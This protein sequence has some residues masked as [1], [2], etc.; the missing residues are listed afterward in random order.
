MKKR[1]LAWLLTL[2]MVL[3][4][5][6][7]IGSARAE[8]GQ[9]PDGQVE[10]SQG[11]ETLNEGEEGG[12]DP[13]EEYPDGEDPFED[14]DPFGI[15]EDEIPDEEP[16]FEE[17]FPD[18]AFRKVVLFYLD[19]NSDG[20]LSDEEW[21][22]IL[23][24]TFLD[25]TP[26]YFPEEAKPIADDEVVRSLAGIEHFVGL[27]E[28]IDCSDRGVEEIDITNNSDL[29]TLICNNNSITELDLRWN[30]NLAYVEC[31]GNE[32]LT[33]YLGS[34]EY[35]LR[36]Y[37]QYCHDGQPFDDEGHHCFQTG[38]GGTITF[39]DDAVF[40]YD[41]ELFLEYLDELGGEEYFDDEDQ[42]YYLLGEEFDVNQDGEIDDEEALLVKEIDAPWCF[43][44]SLDGIERFTNLEVLTGEN[45]YVLA[46]AD[47]SANTKLRELKLLGTS[48]T[49]IDLSAN[50][51]LEKL[52]ITG[53][54]Q[55]AADI[56]LSHNTKLKEL[57][58]Y[59][60]SF[61]SFSIEGLTNLVKLSIQ[62]SEV[63]TIPGLS[64]AVLLEDLQLGT[65]Q[66]EDHFIMDSIDLGNLTK[67]KN[68]WL[69]NCGLKT[70]IGLDKINPETLNLRRN[71]LTSLDVSSMTNL[72]ELLCFSNELET[73]KLGGQTFTELEL[74]NNK[75]TADGIVGFENISVTNCLDVSDVAL[76]TLDVA[77]FNELTRLYCSDCG[78]QE[79]DVTNNPNLLV[80]DCHGNS[81]EELDVSKCPE[82]FFLDCS[83]NSLSELDIRS[84]PGL[85]LARRMGRASVPDWLDPEDAAHAVAYKHGTVGIGDVFFD[86]MLAFDSD[87]TLVQG[88]NTLTPEE[89]HTIEMFPDAHF[90]NLVVYSYDRNYDGCID[91][92][93]LSSIGEETALICTGANIEDLS[94]IEYFQNLD[95]LECYNN[96]LTSLDLSNNKN[97][98]V[99]SCA[100]NELTEIDISGIFGLCLASDGKKQQTSF[101]YF[102]YELQ[103]MLTEDTVDEY[104]FE[105]GPWEAARNAT[106]KLVVDEGVTI[107]RTKTD[108]EK[109]TIEAF[110][111][112][113]F[114]DVVLELY[115]VDRNLVIDDDEKAAI[116]EETEL[117]V[118]SL[119]IA[120]LTGIEFF[121]GLT[122]LNCS[123]NTLTALDLS[124]NVK[125][126]YL[127]CFAN[128]IETLDVKKIPALNFIVLNYEP[129]ET[130]DYAGNEEVIV[131]NYQDPYEGYWIVADP[132]VTILA[133]LVQASEEEIQATIAKFPDP[134]FRK[135]VL[136]KYDRDKNEALSDDEMD[137]IAEET[138]LYLNYICY[139][140]YE[141][142]QRPL[143]ESDKIKDLTGLEYF[144]NLEELDVSNHEIEEIDVTPFQSLRILFC[145]NNL[146]TE[147]D[148]S[149]NPTLVQVDCAENEDITIK[150]GS[151]PNILSAYL[152]FLNKGGSPYFEDEYV[153]CEYY[154]V[155]PDNEW[156]QLAGALTF[157]EG[158]TVIHDAVPTFKGVQMQLN[159]N[160]VLK[161]VVELPEGFAS[162]MSI[163][164]VNNDEEV[165]GTCS[166][167]EYLGENKYCYSLGISPL[168]FSDIITARFY[169]NEGTCCNSLDYSAEQYCDELMAVPENYANTE[170]RNL[171]EALRMYAVCNT[172][173]TWS[174]TTGHVGTYLKEGQTYWGEYTDAEMIASVLEGLGDEAGMQVDVGTTE[175]S[176]VMISLTLKEDTTINLYVRPGAPSITAFVGRFKIV[177]GLDYFVFR[178]ENKGPAALGEATV[179]EIQTTAGTATVTASPMSYVASYLNAFGQNES[180]IDNCRAMIALYQYYRAAQ[181]YNNALKN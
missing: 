45:F 135:V 181:A 21:A 111:D 99:L 87:I 138:G 53:D 44:T 122:E 173:A 152:E 140:F 62:D 114:R 83:A 148:V 9:Y 137:A 116:A 12:E 112:G 15:K 16:T 42:W 70:I 37:A 130:F 2:L 115:D 86:R 129:E 98:K 168:Q 109:A 177:N 75:L 63:S 121:K 28:Y 25:I 20:E 141:E 169:W 110:P 103:S 143:T 153:H 81:I 41:D 167:I 155:V 50:V 136:F 165:V 93:E 76:G 73:L 17:M 105:Y 180:K 38:N 89:E 4:L 67:L 118:Y 174:D 134:V 47:L 8:E 30:S 154:V 108:D 125:L 145:R 6:A 26:G 88:E 172:A 36:G 144:V 113:L 56:D 10:E 96:K 170:L 179:F 171:V 74:S 101:E 162:T 90:R 102:S 14:D 120:S 106:Y 13:G 32:G 49:S 66:Y 176:D 175:L 58:L 149:G 11:D 100:V 64:D 178:G 79:L 35:F 57:S 33:I 158:I 43:F 77:T 82:L 19:Q 156:P 52:E 51:N 23:N 142:D 1:I 91:E 160:I 46:E 80:L 157:S 92:D 71:R 34:N 119:G 3:S 22:S 126:I 24:I 55:N 61:A 166:G 5:T 123:N 159:E 65:F 54:F 27:N 68:V 146:L 107:K 18:P 128:R 147:L 60:L 161:Y 48:L 31:Y 133:E 131:F 72:K 29:H 164:F 85:L 150:L 59:N 163:A 139:E 127:K 40:S 39:S 69:Y 117:Y 104:L 7:P 151:I 94:G 97:L 84:N 132:D 78:L 95:T 124:G